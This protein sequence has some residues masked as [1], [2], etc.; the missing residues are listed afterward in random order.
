MNERRV[1]VIFSATRPPAIGADLAHRFHAAGLRIVCVDHLSPDA[2]QASPHAGDAAK[3]NALVETIRAQAGEIDA[4][5][6]DVSLPG[7]AA[8]I[9]E[10]IVAE[11][12]RI[13]VA[14]IMNG[15]SGDWAGTGPVAE[16]DERAAARAIEMNLTVPMLIAQA[17]ARQMIRQGAAARSCS[18]PPTAAW[19]RRQPPAPSARRARG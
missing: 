19:C 16:V 1:A 10:R 11:A 2:G 12:G 15:A 8:R 18:S 14:A 3:L 9:V 5:D 4:I 7:Q 17:V 6:A 13:D